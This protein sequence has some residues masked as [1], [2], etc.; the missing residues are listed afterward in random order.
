MNKQ[1]L[2]ELSEK[3]KQSIKNGCNK[4]ALGLYKQL[5]DL[6]P[7]YKQGWDNL[8]FLYYMAGSFKKAKMCCEKSLELVEDNY[9]ALKGLGLCLVRL[10]KPEEGIASLKKSIAVN[11]YYFDSRYDLGVTYLELKQFDNALDCFREALKIA[12]EKQLIISR[13]IDHTE[14]QR[15]RFL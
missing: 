9:Y 1:S 7:H 5:V 2:Q 4:E 8:G 3:A 6:Y 15:K 12:P 14:R 11:P 13:A 10:G